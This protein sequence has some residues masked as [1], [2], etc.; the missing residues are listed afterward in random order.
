MSNC[1]SL[2]GAVKTGC[3]RT[4]AFQ[5]RFCDLHK[6]RAV[7]PSSDIHSEEADQPGPSHALSSD[8]GCPV[9]Q[10]VTD[11]RST[12]AAVYYQV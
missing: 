5:S 4:P 12:R 6:P 1:P 3:M 10:L 2:I 7:V 8:G 11:K 9:V